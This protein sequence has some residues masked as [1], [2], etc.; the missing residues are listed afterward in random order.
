MALVSLVSGLR[1][2]LD[3]RMEGVINVPPRC[4]RSIGKTY[5]RVRLSVARR[6]NL[7]WRSYSLCLVVGPALE[8]HCRLAKMNSLSCAG[9][10]WIL[11]NRE[12]VLPGHC[13]I[14]LV[15][16]RDTARDQEDESL[17]QKQQ[18]CEAVEKGV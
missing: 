14:H 17:R 10:L 9:D 4:R 3:Y 16:A 1:F 11:R 7:R 18:Q 15:T 8:R 6:P 12:N 13:A 5:L 2:S